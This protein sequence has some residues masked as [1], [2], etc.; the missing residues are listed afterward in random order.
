MVTKRILVLL[1][2]L[3]VPTAFAEELNETLDKFEISSQVSFIQDLAEHT[4]QSSTGTVKMVLDQLNLDPYF[5]IV[6]LMMILAIE[7]FGGT[8]AKYGAI[9][10][11]IYALFY[12]FS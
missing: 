6:I 11:I 12:L 9:A 2:M 3:A 10:L 8:L 1:L 4:I 7:R 5:V